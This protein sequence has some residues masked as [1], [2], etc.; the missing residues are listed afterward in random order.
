[1]SNILEV[2]FSVQGRLLPADHGYSLYSA[3]KQLLQSEALPE[4]LIASFKKQF[5]SSENWKTE[6]VDYLLCPEL[7][8]SSIPGISDGHKRIQI[9][10]RS[11]LRLRCP[12]DRASY[13]YRLLQNQVLNLRS[14][15]IRLIQPRLILP[16]PS[17]TL[18]A[19]L[20]TF[21]LEEWD[22]HSAPVHFLESCR[23]A[24]EKLGISGQ[25]SIDNDVDGDL[26]LRSLQV[27]GKHILGYG[28][29]VE[30]LSSEDSILL[31][32]IGIGGR[33]HFGCGWFYPS[34]E[35]PDVA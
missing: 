1:M 27:K 19:R 21:R 8:L 24:F 33:K 28:V 3:V 29:I 17:S 30:N 11:R 2:Q 34:K 35:I 32:S 20:V 22:T 26:A 25:I 6:I 7:L 31:Q 18:R 15:D 23:K 5:P 10:Q 13:W 14:H 12:S 4:S 9:Y 16:E